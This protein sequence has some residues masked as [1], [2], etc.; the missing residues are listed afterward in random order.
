M[1]ACFPTM[2]DGLGVNE[3]VVLAKSVVIFSVLHTLVSL[4]IAR[5]N[6]N[7]FSDDGIIA[8]NSMRNY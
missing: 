3:N 5:T 8:K 2:L 6:F 4:L 7:E 1:I